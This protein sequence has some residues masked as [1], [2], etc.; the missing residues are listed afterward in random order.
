MFT[1]TATTPAPTA[2]PIQVRGGCP[3]DCPDA[4]A[5]LTTVENGVAT[6]VHGNPDHPHTDGVLCAKVSR[7]H[8]R[9]YHPERI[10]TPLKRSGP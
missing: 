3:H 10:L 8:E 6:R 5:L 7:Y 2:V 9:S 4:C 1:L